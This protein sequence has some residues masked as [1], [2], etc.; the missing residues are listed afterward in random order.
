[1]QVSATRFKTHC[2]ELLD[3]VYRTHTEVVI[4]KSGKPMA[5]LVYLISA[6]PGM[7][8]GSLIGVGQTV[9]DLTEPLS[10]EW[11]ANQ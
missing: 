4:T 2:L 11:E 3:E 1:M 9:S 5:K 8:V 7:F 10:D 6:E